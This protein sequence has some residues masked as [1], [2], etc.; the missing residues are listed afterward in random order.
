[1][2]FNCSIEHLSPE[3]SGLK[4]NIVYETG[5]ETTVTRF[6]HIF[7][8]GEKYDIEDEYN[9]IIKDVAVEDA[10]QYVCTNDLFGLSQ[11]STYAE[12]IVFGQFYYLVY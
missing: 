11:V 6:D 1:M 8:S 12:L 7:L 3:S 2:M 4:W 9:L 5:N 10:G